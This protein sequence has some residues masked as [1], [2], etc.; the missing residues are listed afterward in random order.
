MST[1]PDH[2]PH[3]FHT[4]TPYV[5]VKD[6]AGAIDFCRRAFGAREILRHTDDT[7]AIS[8]AEVSIG[9]SPIMLTRPFDVGGLIAHDPAALGGASMHF[10]VYVPDVD[11]VFAQAIAAGGREVMPLADHAYG[12]RCGGVMDPY[13]HMW[14]LATFKPALA[15]ER[16]QT[17][18]ARAR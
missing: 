13:G 8:H 9:D 10:Y 1:T 3:G 4:I 15:G 5:V 12:D 2:V 16:M 7:G 6:P 11:A 18:L 14:W 17:R